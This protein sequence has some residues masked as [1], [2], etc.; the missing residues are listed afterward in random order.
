MGQEDERL[1][2]RVGQLSVPGAAGTFARE[3]H[4][5]VHRSVRKDTTGETRAES[6]D[7]KRKGGRRADVVLTSSA[8]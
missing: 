1:L 8:D 2:A 6:A 3:R 7:T 5:T 4:R